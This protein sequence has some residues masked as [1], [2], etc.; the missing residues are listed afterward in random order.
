VR[1]DF[2]E[3]VYAEH[4]HVWNG[5]FEAFPPKSSRGEFIDS[6]RTLIATLRD[7]EFS[8]EKSLV[9]VDAHWRIIDGAH[10]VAARIAAGKPVQVVQTGT[11]AKDR[12][13]P[14][15]DFRFFAESRSFVA[16]GL[17][18]Y[19]SDEMA[20]AY[21]RLRPSVRLAVF[22]P[23]ADRRRDTRALEI[24][25]D[26]GTIVYARSFLLNEIGALHFVRHLYHHDARGWMGTARDGFAGARDKAK[27]CF[28]ALGPVRIALLDPTIDSNLL[29]AKKSLR[30]LY[31][32]HDA[33][34]ISDN[35]E[36]LPLVSGFAFNANS[37]DFFNRARARSFEHFDSLFMRYTEAVQAAGASREDLCVHG[38]GTIAAA[39]LRDCR[40]LDF[41]AFGPTAEHVVA[42]GISRRHPDGLVTPE[43]ADSLIFDPAKHFWYYGQ[44][45]ASLAAVREFKISR[46]EIRKDSHDV[47]LID[48]V[49]RPTKRDQLMSWYFSKV[50]MWPRTPRDRLRSVLSHTGVLPLVRRIRQSFAKHI[51][52]VGTD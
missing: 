21:C 40:D 44:K 37:I 12:Q 43:Y 10:R 26:I 29:D 11:A 9:P 50:G 28:S 15:Y 3:R 13:V 23:V 35:P 33:V 41:V 17:A 36:E 22:F 48:Q 4:I 51:S 1:S 47:A 38:S 18:E 45:F 20:R 24:L 46:A 14:N 7:T 16:S 8:A 31:E 30:K 52:D 2:G 27:R 5:F 19:Y 39:G 34:H 49:L 6:F 32:Q 25:A 42:S